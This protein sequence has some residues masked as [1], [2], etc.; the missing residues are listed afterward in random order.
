VKK[1]LDKI[2]SAGIERV[3]FLTYQKQLSLSALR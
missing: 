2:R 3:G 1:V